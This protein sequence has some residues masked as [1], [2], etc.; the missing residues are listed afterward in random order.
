MNTYV[1]AG[2]IR[3]LREVR[4][5]TQAEL[6][7]KI[8]VSAQSVSRWETGATFPD[9]LLL[10]E[11]AK[12]YGVLVDDLFKESPEGYKNYA[13]RLMAVYENSR[14]HEDFMAA[15]QEYA[16]MVK[17]DVMTA[18]DYRLYGLL[19]VYMS[20]GCTKKA[21]EFYDKSMALAKG[22]DAGMFYRVR[23]QKN[24]L[25]IREG[26]AQNCIDEQ[27]KAVQEAPGNAEEY[28]CLASAL[29]D[30]KQYEE[31]CTAAKDAIAKF[32]QEAMLYGWAGDACRELK[33]YDEAFA[34]W[35]KHLELDSTWLDS[36]Y[37]MGFCYEEL[38]DYEKAAQVWEGI[39]D[40]LTDK[41]FDVEANWPREQAEK[42]REK[43]K[44]IPCA[45]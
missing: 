32:P 35:E 23:R 31:C 34:Y 13:S 41:G 43:L 42:C 37:S 36:Y 4:G 11:L 27:R 1:T 39:A 18:N 12:L 40:H 25:R 44:L 3:K 15:A 45:G 33:K 9:I 16:K 5:L 20:S 29:F 21:F 22:N 6:A 24:S 7:E 26:E 8:G 38:E 14:K 19:H 2:T 28:I 17:A 10:P 30:A